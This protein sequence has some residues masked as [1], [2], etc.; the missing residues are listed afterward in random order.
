MATTAKAKTLAAAVAA[1]AAAVVVVD[2]M[3][4]EEGGVGAGLEHNGRRVGTY[5]RRSSLV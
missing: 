3:G 4:G 2:R 1:V 5:R